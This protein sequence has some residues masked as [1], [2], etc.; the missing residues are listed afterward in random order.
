MRKMLNRTAVLFSAAAV[1]LTV[2][3][4]EANRSEAPVQLIGT[5]DQEVLLIDI[6]NPPDEAL[7][8]ILL[9]VVQTGGS[10]DDRFNDVRLI[11]YRV[12]YER[13]D[14][15]TQVPASFVRTTSGVIPAGGSAAAVNGILVLTSE[16]LTQAPFVALLPQ[17]GGRDPQTGQSVIK[18]NA[19]IDIFGETMAGKNVSTRVRIPLW[20]CAGCTT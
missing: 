12:Q 6:L 1:A 7:G 9:Q 10:T 4:S 16:A 13:T 20:F 19:V 14:G 11:N 3:C 18:M 5:T 17:N 2:G 15:G 8:T